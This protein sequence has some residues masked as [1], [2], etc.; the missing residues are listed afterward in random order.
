M[1]NCRL[2]LRLLALAAFAACRSPTESGTVPLHVALNIG[3]LAGMTQGDF[4][5]VMSRVD[6]AIADGDGSQTMARDLEPGEFDPA[7]DV[8][9]AEGPATFTATVIGTDGGPLYEGSTTTTID[10]DGF[11]VTIV[12]QP[13]RGV[14]IVSPRLPDFAFRVNTGNASL[15]GATLV[16]RNAGSE[17]L[18]WRVQLS[19]S[20]NQFAIGCQINSGDD[21]AVSCLEDSNLVPQGQVTIDVSFAVFGGGPVPTSGVAFLSSVGGFTVPSVH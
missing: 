12:P 10:Q 21:V 16:V 8:E 15:Y 17:V 19:P 9:V 6:L 20:P 4:N 3:A 7:F 13:V 1:I 5:S 14:L 18:T 2:P 11:T